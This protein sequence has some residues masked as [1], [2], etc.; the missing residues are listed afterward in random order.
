MIVYTKLW[1]T[2]KERCVSQYKLEKEHNISRGTLNTL[3]KNGN[4]TVY[5]L[6]TLCR[7]LNCR[8]EDIVEYIPDEEHKNTL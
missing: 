5:T 2:M 1:Q 8:I 4:V 3:R 7:I 6:D